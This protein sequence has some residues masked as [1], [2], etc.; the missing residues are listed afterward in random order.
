[1]LELAESIFQALMHLRKS[2]A[3]FVGPANVIDFPLLLTALAE[4][5][6]GSAGRCTPILGCFEERSGDQP[7]G[8]LE[9]FDQLESVYKGSRGGGGGVSRLTKQ[10]QVRHNATWRCVKEEAIRKMNDPKQYGE[11]RKNPLPS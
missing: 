8:G 9:S 6:C 5:E 7:T 4:R 11:K 10:L 3:T 1:M 2:A